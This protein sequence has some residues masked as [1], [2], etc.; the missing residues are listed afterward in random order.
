MYARAAAWQCGMYWWPLWWFHIIFENWNIQVENIA[1]SEGSVCIC[2][3]FS[4]RLSSLAFDVHH[5]VKGACS[6][7]R[8]SLQHW[9]DENPWR[10]LSIFVWY[11]VEI[12][13][14]TWFLLIEERDDDCGLGT[15]CT[16]SIDMEVLIKSARCYCSIV[17][18]WEWCSS[19]TST[20]S[21]PDYDE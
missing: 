21:D 5:H 16:K 17:M 1:Y 19:R 8:S 13:A 10:F 2:Q 7:R 18:M 14:E 20:V 4:V 15:F 9:Q 6:K 3:F 12:I 11:G